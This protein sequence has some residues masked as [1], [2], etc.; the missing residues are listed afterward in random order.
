V[1]LL[2][3]YLAWIVNPERTRPLWRLALTAL[4]VVPLSFTG[5]FVG[6]GVSLAIAVEAYRRRER[7][8]AAPW[9]A[10]N[11][12]LVGVFALLYFAVMRSA[13]AVNGAMMDDGWR[14]GFPP[15]LADWRSW[16][17]WLLN[18]HGGEAMAYP[19]GSEMGGSIVQFA[20]AVLGGAAL[21]RTQYRGAT[22]VALT[23]LLVAFAAAALHRYP[24]GY[25]E[26][27]QQYWGPLACLLLGHGLFIAGH[28]IRSEAAA[29]RG[30]VACAAVLVL[31]GVGSL[32]YDLLHPYKYRG[33]ADHRGFSRW[34]WQ[35]ASPDEPLVELDDDLKTVLYDR[36]QTLMPRVYRQ[37]YDPDARRLFGATVDERL[38]MLPAGKP[39]RCVA[40]ERTG[41]SP[42]PAALE[43][44]LTAMAR[45]YRLAGEEQFHVRFMNTGEP[46]VY[47]IWRFEP[48]SS[49]S[50]PRTALQAG[51]T[52]M[53]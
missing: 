23:T 41:A 38:A 9:V 48:K 37:L 52:V 44:W 46:L 18:V 32:G 14:A 31:L 8:A 6:G 53:R 35:F 29:C 21:W 22:I 16:P 2:E 15:G 17:A 47:R 24:Y 45:D 43:A 36:Y 34:F 5:A 28:W 25:G 7:R 1:L 27:L 30:R 50:H 40:F 10:Y 13:Y 19:F 12:A 42:N 4:F 49:D 39:I 26:R 3:P 33:D 11:L 51:A 20:L